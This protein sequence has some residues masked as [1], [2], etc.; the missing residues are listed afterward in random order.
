MWKMFENLV[1]Q[2]Y[3]PKGTKTRMETTEESLV[4]LKKDY[5]RNI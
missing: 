4:Y 3:Y 2:L 1:L 5:L